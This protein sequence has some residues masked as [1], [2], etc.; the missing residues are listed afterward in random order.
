MC[1]GTERQIE[2]FVERGIREERAARAAIRDPH[3]LR[4]LVPALSS[5]LRTRVLPPFRQKQETDEKSKSKGTGDEEFAAGDL[6]EQQ[7][8][9]DEEGED[10]MES[11]Q[12]A[13]G[14][15]E[16]ARAEGPEGEG[17]DE[18]EDA[19]EET[20]GCVVGR[21]VEGGVAA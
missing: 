20:G 19:Q 10:D 12:P 2:R 3:P 21:R 7:D 6:D 1:P 17:E 14:P 8:A 11:Q 5:S 18:E 9:Q 4:G 16:D 15:E 13:A